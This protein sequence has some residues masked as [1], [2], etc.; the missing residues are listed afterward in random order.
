MMLR[1]AIFSQTAVRLIAVRFLQY[2]LNQEIFVVSAQEPGKTKPKK[3]TNAHMV[4][5][6][7]RAESI[8]QTAVRLIVARFLQSEPEKKKDTKLVSFFGLLSL[9]PMPIWFTSIYVH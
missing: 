1:D 8:S 6:Q 5:H 4:V 2:F 3:D 9:I 7:L